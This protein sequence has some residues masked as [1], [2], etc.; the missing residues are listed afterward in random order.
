MDDK[1]AATENII[2]YF[3]VMAN[4][5]GG[6]AKILWSID[7]TT[8]TDDSGNGSIDLL[9]QDGL[10]N[11]VPEYSDLKARISIVNG[12][13]KYDS[14]SVDF[15]AAGE[16]AVDKFTYAIRL[17][18]GTL[19]WATVWVTLKGTN[20][21]PDIKVVGSDSASVSLLET[22]AGL[23]ASGTLTVSD[24]DTSDTVNV[25][26]SSVATSGTGG[27]GGI[28][29]AD[30]KAM[31]S[32]TG[33]TGNAADGTTGSLCWNFN[34]GSQAFDYLAAGETLVLT[35]TLTGTDKSGATDTQTITVTI[36]GTNDGA[37]I[38]GNSAGNVAEDGQLTTGGTL[39]ITDIDT[40]EAELRPI[41]GDDGKK[42]YGA[43]T[44]NANGTWSY[45]LDN[46]N[47][48]VQHLPA[49]QTLTDS[50]LV[51][52]EDGT[53]TKTITVTITGT[54]DGATINGNSAGN[55]AEDGQLTTG[56]TLT[57]TDI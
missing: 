34:S 39:T 4:D 23:K 5:L 19:S 45:T 49:G 13:V 55:V 28:S 42:A 41:S 6:N 52:S 7:D 31:L 51:T 12:V 16:T 32:L 38:N 33:N 50:I 11:S 43:F 27:A 14:S 48:D 2:S 17:A 25:V 24:A 56:G 36:T 22:N 57:I 3:D 18:N 35:Y 26:V 47:T 44:V 20:D 54:N 53:A 30:L 15:L 1:F 21:V 40:G 29:A 37:T 10:A 46:A 8:Q 9:T